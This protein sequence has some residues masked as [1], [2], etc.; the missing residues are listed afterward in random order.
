[1]LWEY[2]YKVAERTKG[3]HAKLI[4]SW[5]KAKSKV[6]FMMINY[7]LYSD[8]IGKRIQLIIYLSRCSKLWKDE[9]N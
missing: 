3:M 9:A 1:M 5:D 8:F 2:I 7:R 6:F 4:S